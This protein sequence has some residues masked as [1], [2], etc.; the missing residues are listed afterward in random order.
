M[1]VFEIQK[2]RRSCR[3][4]DEILA[5]IVGNLRRG[6]SEIDIAR[7]IRRLAKSKSGRIAFQPIVAFGRNSATPHHRPT[8]RR[9]KKGDIVKIDLGVKYQG[10]CSDITRT[11]FT[12]EPTKLQR[13]VYEAV[14]RA[15]QIGIR[16][17]KIGMK[18]KDLDAAA[19]NFLAKE[20]FGKNFIHSLGHGIGRKVHTAPKI[21]PKSKSVLEKKTAI[22]I[23]PG[24][25]LKNK[26]GVR[27]EDSLLVKKN[28][29]ELLT[30]FPK[31]LTVLK[32]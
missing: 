23:E 7:E 10:W 28:G 4:A 30:K 27:I 21:G 22:T 6:K 26:F 13:E 19:R 31:K 32:I 14:L 16:K 24:I 29:V 1:R 2:I 9:L 15:Q 11:F 5:E 18:A 17:I 3:L 12:V 25:Y 8:A 20:G